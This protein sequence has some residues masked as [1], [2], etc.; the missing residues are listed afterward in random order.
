MADPS[1]NIAPSSQKANA[2]PIYF[3]LTD[4]TTGETSEVNLLIRPENLTRTEP[5]RISVRQTLGGAWADNFGPGVTMINISGHTGWRVDSDSND[6]LDRFQEL[7]DT[8]FA[9]WHKLVQQAIVS[10]ND[11]SLVNLVFV[12]GLDSNAD[13]VIPLGFVLL[14][15]KSRPLLV[16]YQIS[17]AVAL[18]QRIS[19]PIV[20]D[21]IA[22]TN[23][24]STLQGA[25]KQLG[26][27]SLNQS[28]TD[29]QTFSAAIGSTIE[30][31][32]V[33]P[34]QSFVTSTSNVFQAVY[35]TLSNVDQAVTSVTAPLI[36]TA[37]LLAQAGA[38]AFHIIGAITTF[39]Q[40]VQA[41]LMAAAGAFLNVYCLLQNALR[42]F[43]TYPDYSDFLGSSNCSSTAG[44]SPISPLVNQNPFLTLYP[45]T[46]Q[47]PPLLTGAAST[48]ANTLASVDPIASGMTQQTVTSLMSTV[49]GGANA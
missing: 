29:L 31:D 42:D 14:R 38:N 23:N 44:G 2:R 36:S 4:N 37:S 3:Q 1:N 8:V 18:G 27:S 43:P 11:P 13:V 21:P 28:I 15:N 47:A 30:S 41:Q 16:Q 24:L 34:L 39:P 17:M 48:A 46:P 25:L 10:G 19:G 12:D 5:S 7:Y 9:R 20:D 32:L 26:L 22:G 6:G 33:E 45:S 35:T 49:A 40:Y